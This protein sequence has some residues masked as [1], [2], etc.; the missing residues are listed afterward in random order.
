M[1]RLPTAQD[2]CV[3]IGAAQPCT[4]ALQQGSA[5][6]PTARAPSLVP[7]HFHLLPLTINQ[8]ALTCQR[9]LCAARS[10]G[11][12]RALPCEAPTSTS[13]SLPG[14]GVKL[15]SFSHIKTPLAGAGANPEAGA[16]S[17]MAAGHPCPAHS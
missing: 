2:D 15:C 13:P 17:L 5:P 3:S 1:Q 7:R 4:V 14:Q 8:H 16:Q 10:A 9:Q 11:A 6:H 12:R